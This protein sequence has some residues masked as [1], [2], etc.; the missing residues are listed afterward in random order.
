V[1]LELNVMTCA[2]ESMAASVPQVIRGRER[3]RRRASDDASLARV[4]LDCTQP[5]CACGVV[6][7]VERTR[8][9]AIQRA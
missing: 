1:A 7:V 3:G 6:V 9:S 8:G 5:S 2:P 4:Q